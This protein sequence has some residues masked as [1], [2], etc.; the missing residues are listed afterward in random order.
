MT[1]KHED[2]CNLLAAWLRFCLDECD[3]GAKW[4]FGA[5]ATECMETLLAGGEA[6]MPPE[7]GS[8]NWAKE[9]SPQ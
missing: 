1:T 2:R 9:G 5:K 7:I 3:G 6:P 8:H 4:C